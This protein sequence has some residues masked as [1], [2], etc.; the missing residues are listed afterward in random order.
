MPLT[1]TNCSREGRYEWNQLRTN[2][3]IPK[4]F[5]GLDNKIEWSTHKQKSSDRQINKLKNF[6][7]VRH[8][9]LVAHPIFQRLFSGA[10]CALAYVTVMLMQQSK[11]RFYL[12]PKRIRGRG[13]GL[14]V[15]ALDSGASGP[16]LSPSRGHCVEFF[17]KTR[18]SHSASL[19]PGV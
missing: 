14:M 5:C 1:E 8:F 16:G 17:G 18:Y 15:S 6:L 11:I 19:H 12:N 9:R 2:F 4:R 13:G 3:L 10:N 7:F